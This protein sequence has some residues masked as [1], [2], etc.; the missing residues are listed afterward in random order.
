MDEFQD[1]TQHLHQPVANINQDLETAYVAQM[2]LTWEVLHCQYTQLSQKISSQPDSPIFYNYSAQQF[3]QLLVLLQRFIETEP[4]EPGT[5][6]EIYARMRNA[7]PMLLQVP[8]VQGSTDI[9]ND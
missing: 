2:C 9:Y 5:R 3:Q 7:L 4:F 6:P 1:E 8:K